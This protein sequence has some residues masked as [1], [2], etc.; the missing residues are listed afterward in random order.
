[1]NMLGDMGLT[2]D[3]NTLVTN[4][5]VSGRVVK[6]R[7]GSDPSQRYYLYVPHHCPVDAP[8]LVS[9]HG[10]SRNARKHIRRFVGLAERYGVVVVAPLFEQERYPDYQ[11]LGLVGER[12]DLMLKKIVAEVERLTAANSRQ[13]YLFGYSGGGQFVHRYAM[14]HP[15]EVAAVA[16]GAAGWYTFPDPERRFPHGLR[17][18]SRLPD[19][20]FNPEAFLRIPVCVLV[21]EADTVRDAALRQGARIDRRQGYSRF[22][23]GQRW[24]EA[25][26]ALSQQYGLATEFRFVALSDADHS[27]TRSVRSGGMDE[28]LF[29]YLF[30]SAPEVVVPGFTPHIV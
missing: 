30:G 17:A 20:V 5:A 12:A 3:V 1:M 13:L 14:A 27:F 29:S 21:G 24:I 9:V 19:L 8:L 6:R 11:R 25:M 26:T 28:Q 23:R 22:E 15:A 7:L 2:D 16:I 18:H 10:I 4:G